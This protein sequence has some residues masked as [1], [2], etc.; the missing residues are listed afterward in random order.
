MSHPNKYLGMP[1]IYV[2]GSLRNPKIP[3]LAEKLRALG[4][5][6]FDDWFAS[7]PQTDFYWKEYTKK[8]GQ[9][10]KEALEDH[11][12]KHVFE[13]DKFHLNLADLGVLVLPAGRSGH[14]ELGF[15]AGL[16]KPT[17]VLYDGHPKRHDIMTSFASGIV[18]SIDELITK[19]QE[20]NLPKIPK[21]PKIHFADAMWLVG[22]LEGEGCFTTFQL[23]QHRKFT[24]KIS[25]AMTDSDVVIR[26]AKILGV[27]YY[28]PYTYKRP[29]MKNIKPIWSTYV[30]GLKAAKW[31][32]ILKPYMG[33]RRQGRISELLKN[34]DVYDYGKR[35][36]SKPVTPRTIR[37][38]KLREAKNAALQNLH[39][40]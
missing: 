33:K 4:Y 21:L 35:D 18:F 3:E 12:A 19:I 22:L 37:N 25:L 40:C 6:V 7:G 30:S 2:I 27:N 8:R 13:F 1:C 32:E 29:G 10:Y 14:L 23:K 15:M 36:L 39:C 11:H 28:G 38:R 5:T 17:F 20:Y 16:K 24:F 31:M 9:S 34:W 26:A